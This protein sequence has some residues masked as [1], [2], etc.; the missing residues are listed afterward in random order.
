METCNRLDDDCDSRTDEGYANLDTACQAGV[1]VCQR[2]GVRVCAG[3]GASVVCDAR[4]VMPDG[5][6]LGEAFA[7]LRAADVDI[8]GVNCGSDPAG[9]LA[10]LRIAG[11]SCLVSAFPSAAV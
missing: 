2:A 1:G 11:I 4:G 5:T 3:D 7:R 8:V 10:A 9:T 6:L